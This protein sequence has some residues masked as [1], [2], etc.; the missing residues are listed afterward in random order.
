MCLCLASRSRPFDRH[1]HM[2]INL[3]GV[4]LI[5][6]PIRNQTKRAGLFV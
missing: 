3:S 4:N 5:Y 2:P 1:K 6:A